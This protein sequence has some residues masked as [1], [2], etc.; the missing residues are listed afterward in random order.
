MQGYGGDQGRLYC[1]LGH[2]AAC[3]MFYDLQQMKTRDVHDDDIDSQTHN[4]NSTTEIDIRDIDDAVETV[5]DTETPTADASQL[6]RSPGAGSL[7]KTEAWVAS[8]ERAGPHDGRAK[9][10][11]TFYGSDVATDGPSQR[12]RDRSD[13]RTWERLAMINDGLGST[14]RDMENFQAD[15]RR[16]VQTFADRL[17]CTDHQTERT[18]FI[19]DNLALEDLKQYRFPVEHIILGTISLVVDADIT[20]DPESWDINEWIIYDD[21]F[22]MLMNDMG[23][24]RDD[25]WTIRKLVHD[26]ADSLD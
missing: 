22:E 2:H 17:E 1:G 13:R 25:L 12:T 15:V 21:T 24:E 8:T 3:M 7:T 4:T 19:I 16:W 11:T 18:Q 5:T 9:T 6:C 26:R 23:L 20:A 14:E 10:R